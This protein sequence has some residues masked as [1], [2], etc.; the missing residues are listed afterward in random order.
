MKRGIILLAITVVVLIAVALG[1]AFINANSL[2]A[3]VKGKLESLASSA[4][5]IKVEFG[6][7]KVQL[8]PDTHF[9]IKALKVGEGGDVSL[10]DIELH[11]RLLPLLKKQIE[12]DELTVDSPSLTFVKNEEGVS[13]K[14]LPK[15]KKAGSAHEASAAPH[16]RTSEKTA[17]K[18]EGRSVFFALKG[19]YVNGARITFVDEQSGSTYVFSKGRINSR[20][21]MSGDELNVP[22]VE[23]S[24]EFQEKFPVEIS[25]RDVVYN[26]ASGHYSA[27]GTL[28]LEDFEADL[29]AYSLTSLNGSIEFDAN[30]QRQRVETKG[31]KAL[32][33]KTPLTIDAAADIKDGGAE[34]GDVT[35]KMFSGETAAR[36]NIGFAQPR[37]FQFLLNTKGLNAGQLLAMFAPQ[38]SLYGT[39][40][41]FHFNGKGEAGGDIKNN[42]TGAG[43]FEVIDGGL[44]GV[45]ILGTVLGA[46]NNLPIMQGSLL[47]NLPPDQQRAANSPDTAFSDL[48]ADLT[49]GGGWLQVR[50]G[51]LQSD[52]FRLVADGRISFDADL[53]LRASIIL[54]PELSKN[55]AERV[56]QIEKILAP[57]RSLTIPLKI[58]GK[59]KKVVI[60]PD[61]EGL[62]RL[63]AEKALQEQAG[64]LLDKA[65]GKKGLGKLFGF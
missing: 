25:S 29:K 3:L 31:L 33:N 37:P 26:L 11:T 48:R 58:S 12:I 41:D 57:D 53:D 35:L 9:K 39:I 32:L 15:K 63:G 16:D 54:S 21:N 38:A 27:K 2:L 20:M 18:E 8:F 7:M 46:V 62:A 64:K 55:L 47:S 45:N 44:R 59:G 10:K 56:K 36:G 65:L 43:A 34:F 52:L 13:L 61:M 40:K 6:E 42:V 50:N 17:V 22:E 5:G 1:I 24:A 28:K 30:E 23:A 49:A 4:L 60:I 51:S 19:V 14:G